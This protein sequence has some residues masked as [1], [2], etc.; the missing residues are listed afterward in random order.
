MAA[1]GIHELRKQTA[2]E[3]PDATFDDT[4][5]GTRDRSSGGQGRQPRRARRETAPAGSAPPREA[6]RTRG[7]DHRGADH[8]SADRVDGAS[9]EDARLARLERLGSLHEKGVLTDEEFAAE[10]ARLLEG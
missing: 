7:S 6:R 8:R 3:F 9:G 1:F 5:G 4:F 10:K 2:E